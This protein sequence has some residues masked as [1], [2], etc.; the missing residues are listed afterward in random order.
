MLL[1]VCI[2]GVVP[3]ALTC[4]SSGNVRCIYWV[5]SILL[6]A[7]LE[8]KAL[9][10]KRPGFTD[11]RYNETSYYIENGEW[12]TLSMT[13]LLHKRRS[14]VGTST[15]PC[16]QTSWKEKLFYFW[17]RRKNISFA[18]DVVTL[19]VLLIKQKSLQKLL[20]FVEIFSK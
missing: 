5:V 2:S 16:E 11:D 19:V 3:S 10:A 1:N 15:A 4:F 8:T 18:L 17:F 20:M 7:K 6:Q 14:Y 12:L 9:K 13:S